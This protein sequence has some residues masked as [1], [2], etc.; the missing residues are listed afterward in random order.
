ML[1]GLLSGTS[2]VRS[3]LQTS[4]VRALR[5]TA[6]YGDHVSDDIWDNG[7]CQLFATAVAR[8]WKCKLVFAMADDEWIHVGVLLPDGRVYDAFQT[9]DSVE[10]FV[11]RSTGGGAE[12]EPSAV[13]LTVAQAK[14]R[15]PEYLAKQEKR[16][17]KQLEL[18]VPQRPY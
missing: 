7:L 17:L 3:W 12:G 2:G 10:D 1:R 4:E 8:A 11:D 6:A 5:D 13:V 9:D 15:W 18:Q 14:K 16:V